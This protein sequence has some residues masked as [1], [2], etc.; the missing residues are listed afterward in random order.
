MQVKNTIEEDLPFIYS[1]FER[2]IDYQKSKGYPVWAGYDK[3]TLINDITNGLQYKIVIDDKIACIF[4]ICYEDS[5]I[6]RDREQGDAIYLHRIVVN[7]LMKGLK[8]FEKVLIWAKNH[9]RERNMKYIR[10]DTWGNN[11][12]II[13]Y[14]K[15]FGF[16]FIENYTTLN[17]PDLPVQHR[18]LY[19]ALLEFEVPNL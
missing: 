1:L 17:S 18:D 13:D 14:Y 5:I 2:A 11:L 9:A 15:S 6:W 16:Y 4:S 3:Q 19:L 12:N 7:P 10:I 8:Q